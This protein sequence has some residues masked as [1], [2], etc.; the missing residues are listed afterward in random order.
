MMSAAGFG[1]SE[2]LAKWSIDRA[3]HHRSLIYIQGWGILF[4]LVPL[5]GSELPIHQVLANWKLLVSLGILNLVANYSL[6]Y[7]LRQGKLSV[8]SPVVATFS[9]YTV[10]LSCIYLGERPTLF[11]WV[12]IVTAITGILV[13]ATHFRQVRFSATWGFLPGVGAGLVS[14]VSFGVQFFLFKYAVDELG[15]ILPILIFRAMT[16]SALLLDSGV[17]NTPVWIADRKPVAALLV[18]GVFDALAYFLYN[19]GIQREY[20]SLVVT[21]CGIYPA[22]TILLAHLFLRERLTRFQ[23][24]GAVL[25]LAGIAFISMG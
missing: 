20:A 6:F 23:W 11:Q 13:I 21:M 8:V 3:G 7:G 25:I 18:A 2:S 10:A 4:L 5:Y 9:V 22:F 19:S 17:R 1:V 16:V 12:G 24:G 14:A 15:P